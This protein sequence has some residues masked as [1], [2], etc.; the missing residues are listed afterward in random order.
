MKKV[1]GF[2]VRKKN[3][4]WFSVCVNLLGLLFLALIMKPC[5][6]M[7]DD[8]TIYELTSGAKGIYDSHTVFIHILIGRALELLNTLLPGIQWYTVLQYL[9]LFCSFIAIY[10]VLINRFRTGTAV[11]AFGTLFFYF[12]YEGYIVL[13]FSKT[14]GFAACAGIFLMFYGLEQDK[15][16][17]LQ[18]AAGILLAL[19]GGMYRYKEFLMCSAVMSAIGVYTLLKLEWKRSKKLAGTVAAYLGSFLLLFSSFAGL[20][21]YNNYAYQKDPEWAAYIQ[22]NDSRSSLMDY[23]FPDYDTYQEEYEKL[24]LS[25]E[26]VKLY[27]SC[28]YGDPELFG[29]ETVDTLLS[30][31]PFKE[32]NREFVKSFFDT[33][34]MG[35]LKIYVFTCFLLFCFFWLFFGKKTW[36]E[37]LALLY[38]A[39][40]IGLIYAYLFYIGRYLVSR[41]ETALWLGACLLV[42]WMLDQKKRYFDC[43]VAAAFC[44]CA[45]VFNLPS[46][47]EQMRTEKEKISAQME[48]NQEYLSLAGMDS[49]HLYL[50]KLNTLTTFNAY[51]PFDVISFGSIKNICK[52]GGWEA[53]NP[54]IEEILSSYGISNPYRDMINHSQVI[55]VDDKEDETLRYLRDHYDPQVKYYKIKEINGQNFYVF[56]SRPFQID[57]TKIQNSDDTVH[58][59]FELEWGTK[60][61]KIQGNAW[62][63]NTNS[64]TQTVYAAV[65]DTENGNTQYYPLTI[66]QAQGV[67]DLM[68]GRFGSFIGNLS[69]SDTGISKEGYESGKWKIGI[70]VENERGLWKIKEVL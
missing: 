66:R 25:K 14:A 41:T 43:R 32:L 22:Y 11:L 24:G 45:L 53:G 57:E 52:L 9:V 58:C 44:A 26:D 18:V 27:I 62:Q 59:E 3:K 34:P 70:L 56:R 48:I 46:W 17:W 12:G 23:G 30:L 35:F 4:F 64:Y 28:N 40:V 67:E 54:I 1:W 7:N 39:S 63:E 65:T 6:E 61:L 8:S 55:V 33:F 2:A 60:K 47:K 49:D 42:I 21:V 50:A 20:L 69:L 68:N 31:R 29:P 16:N 10:Y 19:T 13:Q 36:R 37:I 15:R 38:G 5:F 51:D